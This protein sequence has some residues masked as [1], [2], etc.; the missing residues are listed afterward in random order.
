MFL[1]QPICSVKGWMGIPVHEATDD[2]TIRLRYEAEYDHLTVWVGGPQ[3]AD[4]IEVE[5]GI[6]VRVSRDDG[7]VVGLEVIDA[8]TKLHKDANTL[9]NPSYARTL[10]QD[11]GP[12]A[13][14]DLRPFLAR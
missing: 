3:V 13:L 11:Y 2:R 12:R 7:R 4:Q 1:R 5:S 9:Q 14:T 10:L 8:A 6:Y